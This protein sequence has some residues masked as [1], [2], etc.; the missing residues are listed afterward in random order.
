MKPVL[1]PRELAE[2]I[3]V[4][5]SSI[6]RWIDDGVIQA[7]GEPQHLAG[8]G[9]QFDLH[10][11]DLVEDRRQLELSAE[12]GL[13]NRNVELGVKVGTFDVLFHRACKAF[14]KVYP[15]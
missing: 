13:E 4:S 6:K 5:E 15:P 9:T 2:A 3:G 11:L 12:H 1:S 14:R 10:R 8:L 7:S